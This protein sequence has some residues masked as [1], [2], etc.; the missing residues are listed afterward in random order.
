MT[1]NLWLE[2]KQRESKIEKRES[3]NMETS[4]KVNQEEISSTRIATG[5]LIFVS[6]LYVMLLQKSS[7]IL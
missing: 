6:E 5:F 4:G 2:Y 3:V 1:R 7:Q